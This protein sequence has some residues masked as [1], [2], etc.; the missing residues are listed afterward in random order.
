MK[1][2]VTKALVLLFTV[3]VVVCAF[4]RVE[5]AAPHSQQNG[6]FCGGLNST[7]VDTTLPIRPALEAASGGAIAPLPAVHPAWALA[8]SIDHP[9][10]PLA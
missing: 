10:E 8:Q 6:L 9:P 4:D 5:A 2:L 3:L 7:T 1:P